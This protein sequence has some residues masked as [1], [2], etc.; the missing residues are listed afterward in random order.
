[1]NLTWISSN[2]TIIYCYFVLLGNFVSFSSKAVL[3]MEFLMLQ[4]RLFV[5]LFW[6]ISQNPK[7]IVTVILKVTHWNNAEQICT[8]FLFVTQFFCSHCLVLE[9]F[10][11]ASKK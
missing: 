1:M 8:I 11:G 6:A 4:I 7:S 3:F 5:Q 9:N 10:S 2:H